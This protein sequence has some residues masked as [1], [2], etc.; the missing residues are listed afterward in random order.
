M[1]VPGE[2]RPVMHGFNMEPSGFR[3]EILEELPN[4]ALGTRNRPYGDSL[5]N[6]VRKLIKQSQ[7]LQEW[8]DS[9]PSADDA[10]YL[11]TLGGVDYLYF[12]DTGNI[13]NL[14]APISSCTGPDTGLEHR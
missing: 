4:S 13:P 1:G 12:R 10:A 3:F 9:L 14:L 5:M 11:R 7:P 2:R 6:R 8:D